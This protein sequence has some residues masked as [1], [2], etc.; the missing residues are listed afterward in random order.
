MY[1]LLFRTS[2]GFFGGGSGSGHDLASAG[3]DGL[4]LGFLAWQP[5][6][7]QLGVQE[8]LTSPE[9]VQVGASVSAL[10]A[11]S[12]LTGPDLLNGHVLDFHL[13][14]L[15]AHIWS[16]ILILC[17]FRSRSSAFRRPPSAAGSL[18]RTSCVQRFRSRYWQADG[19]HVVQLADALD[20]PQDRYHPGLLRDQ[21]L[22]GV[23]GEAKAHL[24]V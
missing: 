24:S 12:A 4:D 9:L 20:G 10:L 16:M 13:H 1:A 22:V 17:F 2:A 3:G 21:P 5:S 11:I 19:A 14:S 15:S 23:H 8:P 6:G 18:R 7:L